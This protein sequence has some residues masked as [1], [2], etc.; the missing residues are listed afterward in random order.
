MRRGPELELLA[1]ATRENA[2]RDGVVAWWVDAGQQLF[3]QSGDGVA[4][5]M[6]GLHRF[7]RR[8]E[9]A[10]TGIGPGLMVEID[11]VNLGSWQREDV[12]VRDDDV[13]WR[14]WAEQQFRAVLGLGWIDVA[15][16]TEEAR[17][18]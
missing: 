17:W 12:A 6:A 1:A 3:G 15:G 8:S 16:C 10:V 13:L 14:R 9:R 5:V 11:A 7:R 18:Q 4:A 2:G